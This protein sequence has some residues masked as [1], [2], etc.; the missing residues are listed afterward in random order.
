MAYPDP[1]RPVSPADLDLAR[2]TLARWGREAG[3]VHLQPGWKSAV[4]RTLGV[5]IQRITD[6]LG[7]QR[8]MPATWPE[9]WKKKSSTICENGVDVY[10]VAGH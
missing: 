6:V 7:G 8:R 2:S 10:P 4:A 3:Y 9:R 5:R 1:R